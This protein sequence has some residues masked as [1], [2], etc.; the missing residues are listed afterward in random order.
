M[1]AKT[2]EIAMSNVVYLGVGSNLNRENALLFAVSQLNKILESFSISSVWES[3]AIRK[4]EPDYYNIVIKGKTKLSLDDFY[5]ALGRIEELA[6]KELMYHDGT[7][8]G[9]KRRLDIDIL[10]FNDEVTT[11]PCKLPRHDI[12]DY[13]FVIC[14]L[15]EIDPDLVHPISGKKIKDLWEV[16][17]PTLTDKTSVKKVEFDFNKKA[18]N[19]HGDE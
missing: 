19:W 9:I 16:M 13:P 18:P 3:H 1:C 6:G 14:P 4:A 15:L 12:E 7:N 5:E 2:E 11:V 10:M 17:Q 8:F